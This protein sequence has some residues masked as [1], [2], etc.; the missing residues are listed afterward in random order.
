MHTHK[1]KTQLLYIGSVNELVFPPVIYAPRSLYSVNQP[2]NIITIS[3]KSIPQSG[4]ESSV[5]K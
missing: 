4:K 2:G 5:G 1:S 3:T